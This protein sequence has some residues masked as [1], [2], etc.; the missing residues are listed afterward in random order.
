[1]VID[2][3]TPTLRDT[4]TIEE[5]APPRPSISVIEEE[6]DY[7]RFHV[8]PLEPGHGVTLGN[9]MRRILY[10]SLNGTAVTSV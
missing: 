7:G 5:E 10:S 1:M 9:P 3:Q 2:F 4:V 8:E 6:D